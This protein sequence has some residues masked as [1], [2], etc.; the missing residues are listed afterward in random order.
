MPFIIIVSA[1]LSITVLIQFLFFCK[2]IKNI[3]NDLNR[4]ADALD[5]VSE[6][7]TKNNQEDSTTE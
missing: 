1:I 7:L 3:K 4:I 6:K 5:K 2:N